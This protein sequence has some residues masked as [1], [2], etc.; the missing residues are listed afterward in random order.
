MDQFHSN[1]PS[2]YINIFI[3]SKIF[4]TII[5]TYIQLS[6]SLIIVC[7]LGFYNNLVKF[8]LLCY[9]NFKLMILIII[10]KEKII[11]FDTFVFVKI[12]LSKL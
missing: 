7:M 10:N 4:S 11:T 3:S 12:C 6:Q 9:L 1:S 8:M 2:L 5:V